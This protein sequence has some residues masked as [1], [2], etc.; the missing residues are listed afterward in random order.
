MPRVASPLAALRRGQ[1][2]PGLSPPRGAW[3]GLLLTLVGLVLLAIAT[4]P[5]LVGAQKPPNC[6][7]DGTDTDVCF[8]NPEDETGHAI[9]SLKTAVKPVDAQLAAGPNSRFV[10]DQ[11]ALVQLGKALFWDQQVGSDGQSCGSCHFSAGADPR[12]RNAV[13]P[14]LKSTPVDTTFSFG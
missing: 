1:R 5:M 4:G 10:K 13:S 14:G 3:L 8:F 12:T 2:N 6:K 9:A 11:R 7:A